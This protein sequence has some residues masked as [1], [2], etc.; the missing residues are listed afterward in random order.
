MFWW[1][2]HN[3]AERETLAWNID[4]WPRRLQIELLGPYTTCLWNIFSS[5]GMMNTDSSLDS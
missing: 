5:F 2:R 3:R 1:C 4:R